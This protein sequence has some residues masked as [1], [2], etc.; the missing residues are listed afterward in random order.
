MDII[1]WLPSGLLPWLLFDVGA[2]PEMENLRR[3]RKEAHAVARKLIEVKRQELKDGDS[4]KDILSLL[5][6]YHVPPWW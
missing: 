4:R 2:F 6:L 1:R 3:N 5:G